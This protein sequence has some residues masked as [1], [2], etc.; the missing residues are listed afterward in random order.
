MYTCIY[1]DNHI[2]ESSDNLFNI[3]RILVN[4]IEF[5]P[6]QNARAKSQWFAYRAGK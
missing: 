6:G 5:T 1:N 2:L 4:N 3:H